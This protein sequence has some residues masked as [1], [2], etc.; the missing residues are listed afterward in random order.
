MYT[1]TARSKQNGDTDETDLSTVGSFFHALAKL[2]LKRQAIWRHSTPVVNVRHLGIKIWGQQGK[3]RNPEAAKILASRWR[4]GV[5][6]S[7]NAK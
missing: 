1:H 7:T 4:C 2:W 5:D 3:Q 6:F